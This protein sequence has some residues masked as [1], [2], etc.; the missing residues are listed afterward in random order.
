MIQG[1]NHITLSVTDIKRSFDFYRNI[2][3]LKP[4]C[5]WHQGAYF[6]AGETWFCLNQEI[7]KKN[8]REDYTHFAFDVQEEDF[9]SLSQRI[10][11]SGAHIFKSNKSEGA[12][13]YFCDPDGHKLELHVGSWQTRLASKR[14]SVG[15][16][17]QVEFFIDK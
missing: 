3:G 17:E 6:L 1:I 2:I 15:S 14:N 12:S 4:L 9:N 11:G 8:I 13:L 16:W 10:I 7:E 5:R